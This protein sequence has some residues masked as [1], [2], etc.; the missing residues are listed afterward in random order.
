[1]LINYAIVLFNNGRVE[2]A[3]SKFK[4]SERILA[5]LPPEELESEMLDAR[6]MMAE[7]L[8]IPIKEF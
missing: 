7:A 1:L 5:D 8:Q 3:L 2:D 4:D 6:A